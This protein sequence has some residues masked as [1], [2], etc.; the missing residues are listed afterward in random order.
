MDS[1]IRVD[2]IP[3]GL[4]DGDAKWTGPVSFA[5]PHAA[6]RIWPA[7]T[8]ILTLYHTFDGVAFAVD[9]DGDRYRAPLDLVMLDPTLPTVA[10]FLCRQLARAVGATFGISGP[11]WR[12][13]P[14]LR[15]WFIKGDGGFSGE[16]GFASQDYALSPKDRHVPGIPDGD[17]YASE[18]LILAIRSVRG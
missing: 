5:P 15:M 7:P 2:E 3:G 12:Y 16:Y 14:A 6:Q 18:A 11:Q 17:D 13:N 4:L 8:D 1:R 10:A 9:C